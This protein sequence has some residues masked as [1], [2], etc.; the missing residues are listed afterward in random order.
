[1]R[2]SFVASTRPDA[3]VVLGKLVDKY[4]HC[5]TAEA[6]YIVALGGDGTALRALHTAMGIVRKP[7]FAMRLGTSV[8]FLGNPFRLDD[9]E[10]RLTRAVRYSFHPLRVRIEDIS[11]AQK[12]VLSIND[13]SL[14]R[15][16]RLTAKLL[17]SLDGA[18]CEDVFVGDGI[19]V[20]TPIGSTAYNRSCGG[21]LLPLQSSLLA[22]SGIAPYSGKSWSH[23]AIDDT[24]TVSVEVI[25]PAWRPVRLETD[26]EELRDIAR[27]EILLAREFICTL[28][29]DS[30]P[31]LQSRPLPGG[32][33]EAI[34]HQAHPARQATIAAPMQN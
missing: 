11:G 6:D 13:A 7:V 28:M 5:E 22:V 21:P 30:N 1:M 25:A 29:F 15:Q 17:V 23:I 14:M 27:V 19:L 31:I 4:G 3:Q 8:G 9:L 2:I 16:T 24:G 18:R 33:A 32:V 10:I 26:I 20:A 34:A 12:T